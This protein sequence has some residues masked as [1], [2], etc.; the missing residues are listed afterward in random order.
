MTDRS[1]TSQAQDMRAVLAERLTPSQGH[2]TI[3][4]LG[5]GRDLDETLR[6]GRAFL[7][8][9]A[10]GGWS[11]PGWPSRHGGLGMGEDELETLA[12]VLDEFDR[13]DL[14]PFLIGL[15]TAGPMIIRHGTLQQQQRHLDPIRTG[16][17]LWCQLFSEPDA[18]SDLA[19]LRTRATFD[20]SNW[21]IQGHKLWA[22][23]AS[24]AQ[25][26][27]LLARSNPQA[28]SHRGL[29]VFIIDMS[30][31]GITLAPI[32]QMNGDI[33]FYEVFFDDVIVSDAQRIGPVDEGWRV[34]MDTL[35]SERSAAAAL[36]G[37]GVDVNA[38]GHLLEGSSVAETSHSVVR[39]RA[40]RT[41]TELM[42][43]EM[44]HGFVRPEGHKIRFGAVARALASLS[45]QVR[46]ATAMLDEGEWSALE[47][48][49][50]S[51]SIRG[52]TDEV[53]RNIIGERVLGLPREPR[54]TPPASAP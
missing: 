28:S 30:A 16:A 8:A 49:A 48:T 6:Q 33:H 54:A 53:Q 40:A 39:D 18:G 3:S 47:T 23:R 52:G 5:A 17:E 27:L 50:P 10:P 13:P 36:G 34:A 43:L 38:V 20:G 41:V 31:A 14:Y 35:S 24:I 9:L 15:G 37:R 46:G 11:T 2:R 44:G 21:T 12:T 7:E 42:L 1:T 19:S 32:R 29:T 25:W 26:G 51:V 22:S 45:H 4:L